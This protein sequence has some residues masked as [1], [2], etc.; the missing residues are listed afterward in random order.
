MWQVL[1]RAVSSTMGFG[2][3]FMCLVFVQNSML[4]IHAEEFSQYVYMMAYAYIYV[5][6]LNKTMHRLC[7][8]YCLLPYLF[9]LKKIGVTSASTNSLQQFRQQCRCYINAEFYSQYLDYVL[10]SALKVRFMFSISAMFNSYY[11]YD[12]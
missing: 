5:Y 11:L 9:F 1:Q 8:I 12:D 6:T 7:I 2:Q 10:C 3:S 4:S